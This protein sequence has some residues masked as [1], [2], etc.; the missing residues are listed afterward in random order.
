MSEGDRY[1][2]YQGPLTKS[3]FT[4]P[5]GNFLKFVAMKCVKHPPGRT[6]MLLD[7]EVAF[8]PA[9]FMKATEVVPR[10]VFE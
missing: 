3:Q 7:S 1:Q 10:L 8:F 5:V 4:R 2:S 9:N 6:M